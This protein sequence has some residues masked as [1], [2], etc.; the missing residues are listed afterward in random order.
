LLGVRRAGQ[1]YHCEWETASNRCKSRGILTEAK[2]TARSR[3]WY[4]GLGG[5]YEYILPWSIMKDLRI[6]RLSPQ[7]LEGFNDVQLVNY[8][9]YN[10]ILLYFD[11]K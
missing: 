1:G 2:N 8:P 11:I 5:W 6:L 7:V 9:W 3:H 4:G 10:G